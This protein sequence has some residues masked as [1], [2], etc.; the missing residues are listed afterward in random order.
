MVTQSHLIF[1]N[2]IQ[3]VRTDKG[4]SQSKLAN[5]IG[6]RRDELSIIENGHRLPTKEILGKIKKELG[7]LYTDLYSLE[8]QKIIFKD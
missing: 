2:D 3:S 6:I 7:C 4:Y 5:A 1:K 8:L